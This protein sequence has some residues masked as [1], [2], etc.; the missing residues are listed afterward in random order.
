MFFYKFIHRTDL[1]LTYR[2]KEMLKPFDLSPEQQLIMECL[3]EEDGITQKVISEKLMKDKPSVT[4][5]LAHLEKKGLIYRII[6]KEN[7]RISKVFLTEK[8][9]EIEEEVR[10]T[11]VL[12]CEKT[13]YGLTEQ[14]IN[15]LKE[16]LTKIQDNLNDENLF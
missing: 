5:M 7:R 10:K 9:K 8:G 13:N 14:D 2:F 16:L 1:M 11:A 6:P 4:R 12:A 15:T 3:W